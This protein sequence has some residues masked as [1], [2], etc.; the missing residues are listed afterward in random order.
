MKLAVVALCALALAGCTGSVAE[1]PESWISI[2]ENEAVKP[3]APPAECTP[4]ADPK[5]RVPP[6]TGELAS[7]TARREHA[8]KT[9][10]REMA[11]RRRICAAGLVAQ[12]EGK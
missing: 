2:I 4:S 7:D 6:E 1:V 3:P 5:W 12:T 11:Q 9:A 8:N 10:F